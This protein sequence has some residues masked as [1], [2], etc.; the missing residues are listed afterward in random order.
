MGQMTSKILESLSGSSDSKKQELLDS[1][2]FL[3]LIS[4][5]KTSNSYAPL[6]GYD[7]IMAD[8]GVELIHNRTA[9]TVVGDTFKRDDAVNL[10]MSKA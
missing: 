7:T 3:E 10:A 1:L 9:I 6:L 2:E 4:R 8:S 5:Q